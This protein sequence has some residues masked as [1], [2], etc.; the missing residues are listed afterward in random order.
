MKTT[1]TF[2]IGLAIFAISAASSQVRLRGS[3]VDSALPSAPARVVNFERTAQAYLN[4]L[5]SPNAG[6]VESAL[7]HVTVLR[8]A[9]P[10]L[11]LRDI[12]EKIF[13]LTMHGQTQ[14]IRAKAF[15]AL[16]VFA[17]PADYKDAVRIDRTSGDGVFVRLAERSGR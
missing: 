1:G 14:P 8:I 11:S 5:N 13:D 3:E 12:Q 4:C 16:R 2:V 15:I 10:E 9:Y 7:G 17:H 6:V